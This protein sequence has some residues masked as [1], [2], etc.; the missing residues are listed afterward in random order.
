MDNRDFFDSTRELL[1]K[2]KEKL[3]ILRIVR[4]NI[5]QIILVITITLFAL[6]YFVG[7]SIV[8]GD[9]M[10]PTFSHN[11]LTIHTKIYQNLSLG[12]V[13]I[14]KY[15]DKY[16]IKRVIA[17]AGQTVNIDF[18]T[19]E[20]Y[21][22]NMLLNEKYVYDKTTPKFDIDFPVTVPSQCIF[23]LGDNRAYSL[24]SRSS[25]V[26]MVHENDVIGKAIFI[27]RKIF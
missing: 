3:G 22:D 26:G 7:I 14:L 18:E 15:N 1:N 6:L 9:S 24:D 16:I 20:V 13:V 21:V 8:E 23:V 2:E 25:R 19:G 17:T 10:L 11:D 12:D 27:M 4:K 5:F